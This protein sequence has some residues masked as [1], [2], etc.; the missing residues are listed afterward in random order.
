MDRIRTNIESIVQQIQTAEK[1][2]HIDF[3]KV[4]LLPVSK[5]QQL[6]D[7]QSAYDVGLRNFGENYLRE[8][9]LKISAMRGMDIEWHYIGRVQSKKTRM[10]AENFSWVQSLTKK[11]HAMRLHEQRPKHLSPLNICLQINI[12]EDENKGGVEPKDVFNLAKE[13]KMLTH[14]RL[15][16]IMVIPKQSD[17]IDIQREK[18]QKMKNIF[19]EL[20]QQGF[21]LDILSMGMTND[22][23]LAIA[24]GSTM[25]RIGT[26]IFGQR[27]I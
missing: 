10:L 6:V 13:I 9:M 22:W 23:E 3:N 25:V 24:E 8:A 5:G 1:K 18:F 16:G 7:M 17:N 19:D 15:R 21:S 2:Y 14:L 26:G 27:T 11:K 12:D 20:N 4:K